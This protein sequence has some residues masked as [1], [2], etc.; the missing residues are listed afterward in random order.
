MKVKMNMLNK[1]NE[2]HFVCKCLSEFVCM[3]VL[4]WHFYFVNEHNLNA[5]SL[6]AIRVFVQA[7]QANEYFCS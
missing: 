7:K 2:R 5:M 1:I 4:R 6:N 3:R